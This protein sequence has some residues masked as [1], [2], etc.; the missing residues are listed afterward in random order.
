MVKAMRAMWR[1]KRKAEQ[2]QLNRLAFGVLRTL[3]AESPWQVITLLALRSVVSW[4]VIWGLLFAC[5]G[6]MLLCFWLPSFGAFYDA[7]SIIGREEFIRQSQQF[8]SF[9]GSSGCI[10][11]VL[12][13]L[14]VGAI[15][16]WSKCVNVARREQR[17]RGLQK[18]AS[19]LAGGDNDDKTTH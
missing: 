16:M 9:L 3:W 12:L 10:Q 18:Q 15:S 8:T 6:W 14:F 13:A 5:L 4:L 17:D 11:T 2:K 19:S 7:L 1:M